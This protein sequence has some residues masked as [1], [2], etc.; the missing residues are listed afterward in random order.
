MRTT[1]RAIR[2]PPGYQIRRLSDP[3]EYRAAEELMGAAWGILDRVDITPRHVL[4]TA[5]KN[6]GL[7]L[8][9]F[10]PDDQLVGFLFGFLGTTA[11]GKLKHVSHQVGVHPQYRG[12]H[13]GYLLKRAQRGEVRRQGLDLITWTYDPLETVNAH[14][15]LTQLGAVCNTYLRNVYGELR[16][17]LNRGLPTDRFQV[18]WWVRSAW[19]HERLSLAHPMNVAAMTTRLPVINAPRGQPAEQSVEGI[20]LPLPGELD[21]SFTASEVLLRVPYNFQA[22]KAWNLDLATEWRIQ[23][24]AALE[25]HF[26]AGYFAVEMLRGDLAEGKVAFYRLWRP[27]GTPPWLIHEHTPDEAA[28]GVDEA[29]RQFAQLY[30][31]GLYWKAHEV[32]ETLWR[33]AQGDERAF[34]QGLIRS[35]AAF[36]KLVVQGN[37]RGAARHLAWVIDTLT[38]LEPA[39]RGV[40]LAAFVAGLRHALAVVAELDDPAAFDRALIPPVTLAPAHKGRAPR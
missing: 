38:P 36:H 11:D 37:T 29:V 10:A 13:L 28:P 19:V 8:G 21:L 12:L 30:N 31:D 7:V 25:R 40:D 20:D 9:A 22:V 3:E 16:D 39:Y 17:N 4:V 14:L 35:A 33:D 26:E 32:L 6:G 15:N 1:S 5:Q 2:L 34:L 18:D 24:R 23:T 27:E